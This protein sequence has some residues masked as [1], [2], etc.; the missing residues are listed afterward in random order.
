M[1]LDFRASQFRGAKFISSGSTGT[2]AK[3]LFYD[4]GA[5]S[6]TTP[7]IGVINTAKFNTGS[8]GTDIF[9]YVSGTILSGSGGAVSVF[10]GSLRVSGVLTVGSSSVRIDSNSVLFSS[11]SEFDGAL[12]KVADTARGT[13]QFFE[14]DLTIRGGMVFTS[15]SG[16]SVNVYAG[17]AGFKG[18]DGPGAD[19]GNIVLSTGFAAKVSGNSQPLDASG[20]GGSIYLLHGSGSDS[21]SQNVAGMGGSFSLNAGLGGNARLPGADGGAGAGAGGDVNIIAGDGGAGLAYNTDAGAGAN[22]TVYAGNAG[23]L[24]ASFDGNNFGGSISLNAGQGGNN[25]ASGSGFTG[26]SIAFTAGH[27]GFGAFSDLLADYTKE[28]AAGGMYFQGATNIYASGTLSGSNFQLTQFN[29]IFFNVSTDPDSGLFPGKD[30]G[31]Y[32]SGTLT[33]SSTDINTTRLSAFG[34]SVAISGV[35]RVGNSS[36]NYISQSGNQMVFYDGVVSGASLAKLVRTYV[37]IGSYTATTL[38]SSNPQVAGQAVLSQSEVG[39]TDIRLRGVLS[40][41]TGS[42][43]AS[44]RLYNLTSASYVEI[45]GPGITTLFTLSQTPVEVQS[46]NLLSAINFGTGSNIYECQV[47]IQTGSQRAILGSSMFVSI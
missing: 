26:G 13:G 18:D 10:G 16:G 37:P 33:T 45:G 5:D 8:I 21:W 42:A 3:I 38:T 36:S 46:I 22:V 30:L 7:N 12:I 47:H 39:S 40:T 19:G 2:G 34:G 1:A 31:F 9:L 25:S 43:T 14:H 4:I 24:S 29:R 17:N 27:G 11:A 23:S 41:T 32:V 20:N 44:L 15:G 35:L 6:T 28:A